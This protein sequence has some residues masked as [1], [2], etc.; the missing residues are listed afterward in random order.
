ML[1]T[2]LA[3][4]NP[5]FRV[6]EDGVPQQVSSFTMGEAPMTVC[7][8]IEFSN[9]FQSYWS[10]GWYQTLVAAYGFVDTLKPDDYVAVVAFDMR[11]EILTDFTTD[12]MNA[13][14]ILGVGPSTSSTHGVRNPLASSV[15]AAGVFWVPNTAMRVNGA[16]SNTFGIKLDGQ[17]ITNGVN[18]STSQAQT[19]PSVD[20][21][22]EV[23]IQASNYSAE[24]LAKA[25]QVSKDKRLP[26]Y[27][28][29]QPLY[30]LY[31]RA[32]IGGACME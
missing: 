21:L 2:G 25:I 12:R 27:Q 17:D 14:P 1:E 20:S 16:P 4:E 19:Q 31:D 8:V 15:L 13:L 29:L 23:A 3:L 10:E 5:E 28:C 7:M 11:P 18:T 6:L 26:S 9:L 32:P 30:N 22:E 24:R